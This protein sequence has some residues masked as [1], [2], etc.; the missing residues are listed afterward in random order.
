MGKIKVRYFLC[1]FKT[2]IVLEIS[3]ENVKQ[4]DSSRV[5]SEYH[6]EVHTHLHPTFIRIMQHCAIVFFASLF[7][8]DHP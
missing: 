5:E 4:N 6:F 7:F 1:I 2:I 8:H 3:E